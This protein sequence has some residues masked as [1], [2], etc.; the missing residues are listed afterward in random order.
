MTDVTR[1]WPDVPPEAFSILREIAAERQRQAEIDATAGPLPLER[2]TLDM[3]AS[4][5]CEPHANRATLIQCA[6][7]I[8][9]SIELMDGP[10]PPE[11]PAGYK[12][13]RGR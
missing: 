10:L 5:L 9:R 11:S 2:G 8:L 13:L 6:A 12:L 1:F 3:V 4:I 7:L